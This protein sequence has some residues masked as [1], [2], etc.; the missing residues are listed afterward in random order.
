MNKMKLYTIIGA[1]LFALTSTTLLACSEIEDGSNDM[2]SWPEVKDYVTT[3]EHPCM[4]HTETD[5]EFVKG[6]VQAGAQPW[7]NAFDHLSRGGNSLSQYNYKA[8]PV[9]LGRQISQ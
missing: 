4:L 2:S 9:K 5:F 3:L 7:K 6:K 8:S 1:G